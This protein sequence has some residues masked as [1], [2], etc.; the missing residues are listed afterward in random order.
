LNV[1]NN[2]ILPAGCSAAGDSEKRLPKDLAAR[3]C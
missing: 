1:F 3:E 2:G